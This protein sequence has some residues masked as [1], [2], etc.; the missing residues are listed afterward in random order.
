MKT[1][2][3][4]NI[5]IVVCQLVSCAQPTS[6]QSQDTMFSGVWTPQEPVTLGAGRRGAVVGQRYYGA[7]DFFNN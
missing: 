2:I 3:L 6:Q 5:F 1:L 4:L 7:S